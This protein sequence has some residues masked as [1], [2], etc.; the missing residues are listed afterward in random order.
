MSRRLSRRAYEALCRFRDNGERIELPDYI[1]N[2]WVL[3][4]ELGETNYP[5][6][7]ADDD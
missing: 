6:R 7:E 3:V 4:E 1:W 5:F 2:E